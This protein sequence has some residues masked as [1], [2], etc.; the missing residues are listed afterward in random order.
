[1]CFRIPFVTYAKSNL[2]PISVNL[3]EKGNSPILTALVSPLWS[4]AGMLTRS[5]S[6]CSTFDA[7]ATSI[8]IYCIHSERDSRVNVTTHTSLCVLSELLQRIVC[9]VNSTLLYRVARVAYLTQRRVFYTLA[10][11]SSR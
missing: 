11:L 5:F 3:K 10:I 6:L 7:L 2:L 1:M 9:K 4:D 8:Q